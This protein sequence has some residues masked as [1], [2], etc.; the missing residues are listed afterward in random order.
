MNGILYLFGSGAAFF[1]GIGF[2]LVG[3]FTFWARRSG[4]AATLLAVVGLLLVACSA[5]PLSYWHYGL[6][7][8]VSTLWLVAER[9][10]RGP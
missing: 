2:I 8:G 9:G 4:I 3:V 10:T 6:A 7:G 1:V 5:T